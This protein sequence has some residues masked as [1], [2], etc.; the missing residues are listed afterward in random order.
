MSE[1]WQQLLSRLGEIHDL[2]GSCAV[3]GLGSA[4]VHAARQ[5]G[6]SVTVGHPAEVG[7]QHVC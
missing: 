7:T 5:S 4:D 6:Q 3:T 2:E 1:K